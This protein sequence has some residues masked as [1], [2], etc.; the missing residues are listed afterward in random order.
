[1]ESYTDSY[2]RK[3]EVSA[4]SG[5]KHTFQNRGKL[6]K[7]HNAGSSFCAGGAQDKGDFF[8]ARRLGGGERG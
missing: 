6:A 8:M 4:R 7:I 2:T 5:M 1:M 3:S